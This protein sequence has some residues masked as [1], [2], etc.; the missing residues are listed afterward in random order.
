MLII[1]VDSRL[2][3]TF[4]GICVAYVVY[5]IVQATDPRL[6]DAII[7][8][9]TPSLP[10]PTPIPK[11]KYTLTIGPAPQKPLLDAAPPMDDSFDTALSN[12][13]AVG[14]PIISSLIKYMPFSQHLWES[15][16]KTG[17]EL[18]DAIDALIDKLGLSMTRDALAVR[19]NRAKRNS[20][21]I[22]A[23]LKRSII[24]ALAD[25]E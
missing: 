24:S 9:P 8:I 4:I 3:S 18:V 17:T 13:N 21:K 7:T 10:T 16:K 22:K 5:L 15:E 20:R 25:D 14:Q 6:H 23:L 11:P 1:W 19:H 12:N 2:I